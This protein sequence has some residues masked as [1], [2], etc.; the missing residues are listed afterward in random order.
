MVKDDPS[1]TAVQSQKQAAEEPKQSTNLKEASEQQQAE[2]PEEVEQ[3]NIKKKKK[4][5][6]LLWSKL[7]LEEQPE[8]WDQP[9]P[10]SLADTL[11]SHLRSFSSYSEYK[12]VRQ[13]YLQLRHSG[14]YW[15]PMTMEE[16]HLTLT[17][18]PLGTFLIR[19]S[20]QPD[21]FF[22]LSYQSNDGPTSVRVL[23]NNLLFSLYGSN[24]TFDSLF[25]LLDHYTSPPCKLTLPYRKLRP[26]WLK[27]ICRRAFIRT[28]GAESLNTLP[29][30]STPV[31][32]YVQAYPYSI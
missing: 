11:P 20:G 30:L 14:Y 22:T 15:G 13:T 29:G 3:K 5:K 32:A 6:F 18:T 1:N 4:L 12:L 23:L 28:H 26:E 16:A 31:R 25:T 9:L 19:D 27:Q 7:S 2:S 8:L 21:V 10:G 24:R 17:P